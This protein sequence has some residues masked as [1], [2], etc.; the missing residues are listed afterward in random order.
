MLLAD[1]TF[2]FLV[3][4]WN[5]HL[6]PGYLLKEASIDQPFEEDACHCRFNFVQDSTLSI[7]P[8][9]VLR[10]QW[11]VGDRTPSNFSV[12]HD[13]TGEVTS[14]YDTFRAFE[15]FGGN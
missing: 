10:Y 1:S 12:I 14:S 13:A 9:L 15:F 7:D 6:P 5:D 4:Q 11:F 3:E 2:R 8:Q